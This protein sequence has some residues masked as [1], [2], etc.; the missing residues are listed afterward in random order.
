MTRRLDAA[1]S[2]VL[3]TGVPNG[4]CETSVRDLAS[5]LGGGTPDREE[6]AYWRDGTIPWITP[7]D[8]TANDAKYIASG[9]ESI[10]D[11]GLQSSNAT[12]APINSIVFST[13]GTVGSMALAAA[14]ISCNQSCEILVPKNGV[15]DGEFLYYLLHYGL[16]AFIRLSGGTTFGAIT[17]RDIARV[18]FAVPPNVEEQAAIARIL[19]AVDSAL[20]TTRAAIHAAAGVRDAL[21]QTLLERGI[22]EDGRVRSLKDAPDEFVTTQIGLLPREWNVVPLSEIANVERG[23]FSPRPRNDPRYYNGPFPFIQT[24]Q[25][26]QAKG[27]VITTFTQTLNAL[28]KAVSREFPTGTVMLTIAANIG[29]TAILGRP[30]CAPDSLVGIMAKGKN[31]PRYMELCL[32]RLKPRLLALAPRSAQ[33]NINLTFL[34]PLRIPLPEPPEQNRIA[35]VIDSAD[36][37]VQAIEARFAALQTLRSS[38]MHDL[39]AGRVRVT[40]EIE[41]A[42]L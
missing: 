30:M 36:A 38:L 16:G 31:V 11:L 5:I 9:I 27:R 32:R 13:R 29:E 17:R 41:A 14:P 8:L 7:T 12:L 34:K 28:G 25:V 4:W 2:V 37:R 33:A 1:N 6:S 20:E 10:S 35:S 22:G 42:A 15:V 21:T 24:G 18:R 3:R 26:A 23:R 39:L 40:K 19:S